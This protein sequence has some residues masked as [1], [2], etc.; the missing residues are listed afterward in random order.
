MGQVSIPMSTALTEELITL[1]DGAADF[2]RRFI[3][4]RHDLQTMEGFPHDIW[5][6]MADEGLLGMGISP[7]YGGMGGRFID[8]SVTGEALARWG[9]NMGIVL[10]WVI[11]NAVSRYF[12]SEFGTDGQRDRLLPL[13][14]K[15]DKS[16]SIAISEPGSMAHPRHMKTTATRRGGDYVINGHKSFLTNGQIADIF[17]VLTVTGSDGDKKQF[18]SFLIPKETPGTAVTRHISLGFL[19][20]SPHCEIEL[21]NC[22][23]PAS[24]MLG[25]DGTAYET[26]AKPFRE[27]EEV[28]LM[29]P[30]IGGM[31][32]QMELLIDGIREGQTYPPTDELRGNLGALRYTVDT[33]RVIAFEAASMLDSRKNYPEFPSL[34]LSFRAIANRFESLLRDLRAPSN[35]EDGD[36][37][38]VLTKD[39][40]ESINIADHVAAIKT[41]KMGEELL[42]GK[43]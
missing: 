6:S 1:R 19:R 5:R 34:L 35:R 8:I 36:D 14:A 28:C 21:A 13:L 39:L 15:G 33:L 20:P 26:M 43:G 24:N 4:P 10:S 30:I 41:K 27:I 38:A 22:A 7:D 37:L 42:K 11:H 25:K 29:G 17:I 40:I 16:A 3:A 31:Q 32:R 18:T 9:H 12:I 2:A 23:V